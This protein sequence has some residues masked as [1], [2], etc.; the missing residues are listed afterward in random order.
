MLSTPIDTITLLLER[1]CKVWG[2]PA[3]NASEGQ[4]TLEVGGASHELDQGL[5][6]MPAYREFAALVNELDPGE[7]YELLA[8]AAIGESD[9]VKENWDT[10]VQ[11][12]EALAVEDA[13]SE[14]VR[15]LVLTDA[16]EIGLDRLGYLTDVEDEDTEEDEM[17][18]EDGADVDEEVET[19]EETQPN[20]RP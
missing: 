12:A 18:G 8:V 10:A 16:V 5:N 1:A 9:G 15:L 11:R 4:A 13:A 19:A 3:H 20:S 17:E 6:H 14:L 7:M 2:T